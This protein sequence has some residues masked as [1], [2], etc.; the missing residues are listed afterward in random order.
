MKVYQTSMVNLLS[1]M[2]HL[3]R[4]MMDLPTHQQVMIKFQKVQNIIVLSGKMTKAS[5]IMGLLLVK[6]RQMITSVLILLIR[7]EDM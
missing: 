7:E 4:I 5:N 6:Q 1:L 2:V 3:L